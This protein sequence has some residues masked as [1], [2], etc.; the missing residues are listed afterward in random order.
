MENE[1]KA[2]MNYAYMY[3]AKKASPSDAG[4]VRL[5]FLP[6]VTSFEFTILGQPGN[7]INSKLTT[8]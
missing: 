7:V 5:E 6:L 8:V 4:S 1:Y 2:N 3:A